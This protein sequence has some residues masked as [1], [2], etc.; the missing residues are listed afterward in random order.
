VDVRIAH[1]NDRDRIAYLNAQ[2]F[3]APASHMARV[4]DSIQPDAW[5]VLEDAGQILA[6][7]RILPFTQHFGGRAVPC[8]GIASVAVSADARGRGVGTHL[9]R[10]VLAELRAEGT[11]LS[12]LYPATTPLYR[13]AGYGFA[14]LRTV[15]EADVSTLPTAR[16]V[17]VEGF[18]DEA[19]ADL[20][21]TYEQIAR[22]E[23]G[24]TSRDLEMWRTRVLRAPWYDGEPYRYLVR[25][26]GRVTG[27][28][29]YRYEDGVSG[30]WR[31]T[32]ECR[33][34]VWTTP[35]SARALLAFAARH[36]STSKLIRWAGPPTEPLAD[37]TNEDTISI[38][39]RQR[40]M[41]RL[42]DM[43]A[44]FENRGYPHEVEL[45]LAIEVEDTVLPEN[46]GPWLLQAAS[47]HAKLESAA[48]ADVRANASTW[49]SIW[50]GLLRARDAAQQL[51]GGH[52][53][54]G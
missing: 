33:D 42:V 45:T 31:A 50:S 12:A 46:R 16:D 14:V 20:H 4:R 9:M 11:P 54:S 13:D 8:A 19:I 3:N 22:A 5:R 43:R 1:E 29:I 53:P 24:I 47:G 34:F 18:G 27:W 48:A 37:L 40:Q 10:A 28:I 17:A 30:D 23:N 32:I 41:I 15:W 38:A 2:A 25:E 35:R 51:A 6:V 7:L 36:R 39:H 52:P 21:A 44:A 49:A 26:D